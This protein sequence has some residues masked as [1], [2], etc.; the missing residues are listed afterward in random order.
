MVVHEVA[1]CLPSCAC[2]GA[3]CLVLGAC[4][5]RCLLV[6]RFDASCSRATVLLLW[7]QV[8]A[9]RGLEDLLT[10]GGRGWLF[11]PEDRFLLII[12]WVRHSRYLVARHVACTEDHR[13][14]RGVIPCQKGRTVSLV[15]GLGLLLLL[16][17]LEASIEVR[18]SSSDRLVNNIST[19][20]RQQ[21]AA[22]LRG[23]EQRVRSK[24]ATVLL[25]LIRV[26][27]WSKAIASECLQIG[28]TGTR[29]LLLERVR[30]EHWSAPRLL[31]FIDSL[32][33]VWLVVPL[34]FVTC[35]C[36]HTFHIIHYLKQL[37]LHHLPVSWAL[38]WVWW[39]GRF[40]RLQNAT[41]SC[42]WYFWLSLF[43]TQVHDCL[44]ILMK[45]LDEFKTFLPRCRGLLHL[46]F[47]Y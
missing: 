39:S 36:Y 12:F 38:G 41:A 1:H 34:V 17:R 6:A 16:G 3:I 21:A 27:R 25:C 15:V 8:P 45:W 29:R 13:L 31:R 30:V 35:G 26:A 42:G 37:V 9:C 20:L 18:A 46:S 32:C 23:L 33:L 43:Y 44:F 4:S 22:G 47:I 14:A 40:G 7:L 11:G 28:V 2:L 5:V 10:V 24:L 19:F